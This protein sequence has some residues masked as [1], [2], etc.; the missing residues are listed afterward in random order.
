RDKI[1][2]AFKERQLVLTT[3]PSDT[4]VIVAQ[5]VNADNVYQWNVQM[6]VIMTYATN[7]NVTSQ[8]RAIVFLSI[9]RVPAE[10]SPSGIAIRNWSIGS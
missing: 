7:N 3:V 4:P 5:G 9:V 10:Q 8:Q 6:P 2:E 1:G